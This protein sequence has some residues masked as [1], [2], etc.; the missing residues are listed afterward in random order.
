MLNQ[1]G[2]DI[3]YLNNFGSASLQHDLVA[4]G[5]DSAFW[6]SRSE[7]VDVFV[8]NS[9]EVDQRD[10]FKIY[11]FFYQRVFVLVNKFVNVFRNQLVFTALFYVNKYP[12]RVYSR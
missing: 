4:A 2:E 5:Y 12:F 10:I 3:V 8:L 6:K 11:Y 7:G 1:G 9:E